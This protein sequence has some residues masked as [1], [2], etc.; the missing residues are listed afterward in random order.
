MA[1]TAIGYIPHTEEN[2]NA[3]RLNFQHNGAAT[4]QFSPRPP[5]PPAFTAKDLAGGQTQVLNVRLFRTMDHHSVECDEDVELI[6]CLDI[7]MP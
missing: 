3:F 6:G 5:V 7:T 4:N 1:L 2:V